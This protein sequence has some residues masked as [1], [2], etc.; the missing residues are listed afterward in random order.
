MIMYFMREHV[1]N[2]TLISEYLSIG[3]NALFVW[4]R[5]YEAALVLQYVHNKGIVHSDLK[6][7]T[8]LIGAGGIAKLT[9]F[10]IC[11][12]PNVAEIARVCTFREVGQL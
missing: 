3:N 8:I 12:I 6:C 10:G 1:L 9:D 5:V 4:K 7:D 11:S 2:G